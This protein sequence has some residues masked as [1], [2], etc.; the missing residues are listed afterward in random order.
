MLYF[1][2]FFECEP[3]TPSKS[4]LNNLE[5][6]NSTPWHKQTIDKTSL[7]KD[8]FHLLSI[9][10]NYKYLSIY[11]SLSRILIWKKLPF[12]NCGQIEV[13]ALNCEDMEQ[14]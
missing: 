8:E 12:C 2:L 4:N 13:Y 11:K 10:V 14:K 5:D 7:K 6:L 3:C 9:I 1:L